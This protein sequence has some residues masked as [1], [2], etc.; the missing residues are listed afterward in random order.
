MDA[1]VG[2]AP[3]GECLL[4]QNGVLDHLRIQRNQRPP[5]LTRLVR[6]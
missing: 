6:E 3:D 2:V 1:T 5:G 4:S